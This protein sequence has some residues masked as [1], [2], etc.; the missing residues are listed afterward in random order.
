MKT[1]KYT[2]IHFMI[3]ILVVF[4]SCKKDFLDK[5]PYDAVP[6]ESAILTESDLDA[7]VNGVYSAMRGAAI[8]GR[9]LPIMNDIMADNVYIFEINSN[10]YISFNTYAIFDDNGDVQ[11]IW[12][13]AYNSILRANQ[14]IESDLP[15]SANVN[16]LVGEALA[17]RACLYFDLIR[18]FGKP[19]SPEN[20]NTLGVPLILT[21]DPEIKPARNTVGEVYNQIIADLNQAISLMTIEKNSEYLSIWAAK[22]LLAKVYQYMADWENAKTF[23][24]DVINNGGYA[25]V[26]SANFIGYWS[27]PGATVKSETIFEL[28][29][30]IAQNNGN[31]SLSAIYD[32]DGYGDAM[33]DSNFY[34]SYS[35]GDIRK[36]LMY[37]ALRNGQDV[38]WVDKFPNYTNGTDVDDMKILRLAEIYLIAAEATY[39]L[40]DESTAKDYLN[41]I[42]QTREPAFAGYT[43]VGAALLNDITNER[44]KELAFEGNR[45]FDLN[46]LGL[47]IN[48]GLQSPPDALNISIDDHRRI[49]PI[50]LAELNANPNMVQNPGY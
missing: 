16:Q 40:G 49:L 1:N 30:D 32:D 8:Y 38:V 43:S 10:R 35:N 34:N 9:S 26:D 28:S 4:S 31:N 44:R 23:S 41:T 18:T 29:L 47:D 6:F 13:D 22:G 21:Y 20:E 36:L 12:S 27:D 2:I 14:A 15:A 11:G 17:A 5:E 46:R 33:C 19:Y 25:L 50:P 48:R 42:A 24:L 37:T 39:N 3:I 7:A 45:F